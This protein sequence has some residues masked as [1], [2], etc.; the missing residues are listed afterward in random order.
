MNGILDIKDFPQLTE[1]IPDSVMF[2]VSDPTKTLTAAHISLTTLKAIISEIINPP[3]VVEITGITITGNST[4]MVGGSIQ[5]TKTLTPYNTTQTNIT[6]SSSNTSIATVSSTGLVTLL[7]TGTVNI[8]A[9]SSIN[10][11]ISGTKTI[12]VTEQSQPSYMYYGY[13]NDSQTDYSQVNPTAVTSAV[14]NGTMIKTQLTTLGKTS[15]SNMNITDRLTILIPQTSEL[16]VLKDD[17]FGGKVQFQET[18]G[19]PNT[20]SNGEYFVTIDSVIYK[21][22]GEF[23]IGNDTEIYIYIE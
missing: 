21:V 18:A 16:T 13:Y 23:I 7:S 14:A 2:L 22:Y 10:S 15:V 5:L 1:N 19:M 3:N 9:T 17:G 11:Q 4:G 12:T 20:A 6:W 8:T